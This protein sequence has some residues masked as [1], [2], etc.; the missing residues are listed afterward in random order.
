[1]RNKRGAGLVVPFLELRFSKTNVVHRGKNGE[2]DRD[3][4]GKE[5]VFIYEGREFGN[6]GNFRLENENT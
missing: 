5:N 4:I 2:E 3:G 1:M 6:A